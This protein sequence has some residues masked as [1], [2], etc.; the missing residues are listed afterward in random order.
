MC[1]WFCWLIK[2]RNGKKEWKERLHTSTREWMSEWERAN[3]GE[4]EKGRGQLLYCSCQL[5]CSGLAIS[6]SI[7][8]EQLPVISTTIPS[9]H[10]ENSLQ[11]D[12]A[13]ST[14]ARTS[15][16]PSTRM[17]ESVT[18]TGVTAEP[19]DRLDDGPSGVLTTDHLP[20]QTSMTTKWSIVLSDP[21]TT[22]TSLQ[23]KDPVASD[24]AGAANLV[25]DSPLNTVGS[26]AMDHSLHS[27]LSVT[28]LA[29]SLS[30]S[31]P[32]MGTKKTGEDETVV[33]SHPSREQSS[34][35]SHLKPTGKNRV[36]AE[37]TKLK[38][39]SKERI[40][41]V[42]FFV[43]LNHINVNIIVYIYS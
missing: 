32:E 25:L 13:T 30:A 16:T 38:P 40:K 41:F 26:D 39:Y 7:Y 4:R 11:S 43:Y 42:I 5:F 31:L 20:L 33:I 22:T 36:Y 6:A 21:D 35:S 3:W 28:S 24:S 18:A 9:E 1:T 34:S 29:Q 12:E 10:L 37:T 14:A 17:Y 19:A 2:L 23:S 27:F 8:W 15:A